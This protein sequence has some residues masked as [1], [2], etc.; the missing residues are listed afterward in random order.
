[1]DRE[2]SFGPMAIVMK[3]DS[4][5]EITMAREN[6]N[7]PTPNITIAGS[8][9]QERCMGKGCLQILLASLKGTSGKGSSKG[10][11]LPSSQMGIAT[12]GSLWDLR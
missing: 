10:K 1:M 11:E 7:G 8:L 9:R 6:S 2:G 12:L 3:V 4:I 5:M